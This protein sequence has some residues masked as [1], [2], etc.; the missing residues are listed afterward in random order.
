MII[1]Y[2][3]SF[4]PVSPKFQGI[5]LAYLCQNSLDTPYSI[6][7]NAIESSYTKPYIPLKR[8]IKIEN[9]NITCSISLTL[10]GSLA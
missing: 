5:L 9:Y 2:L 4:K 1:F 10:T 7:H 6:M 3:I 8:F